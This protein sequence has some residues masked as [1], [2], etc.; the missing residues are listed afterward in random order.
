MIAVTNEVLCTEKIRAFHR[1]V[2]PAVRILVLT[3]TVLLIVL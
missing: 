1:H 2:M 3:I